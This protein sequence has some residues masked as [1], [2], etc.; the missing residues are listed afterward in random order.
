ALEF[1]ADLLAF[2][3]RAQAGALDGRNVHEHVLAAVIRLDEAEAFLAVEPLHGAGLHELSLSGHEFS[4]PERAAK[5]NFR[6]GPEGDFRA[7]V[8]T[9]NLDSRRA[10]T[11][12]DL[13]VI[14]SFPWSGKEHL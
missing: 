3:Q 10:K 8:A 4:R 1:E 11:R 7:G 14:G 2:V 9:L 5:S 13:Q 12:F 6:R